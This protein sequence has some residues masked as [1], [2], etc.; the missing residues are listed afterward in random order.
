M[1]R[2][3]WEYFISL[4]M[5][6]VSI[7][8]MTES[9]GAVTTLEKD[10]M[11]LFTCGTPLKGIDIKIDNPESDGIGEICMK[12]RCIFMGYFKNEQATREIFDKDGYIHSGD[13]GSLKDGFLEIKG[14]IKELIITAGGE[15]I[16]PVLI[17]HAF[18]EVCHMCSN[19]MIIG[20]D[21]KFLSALITLKVNIDPKT[22][23][24][25]NE[26]SNECLLIMKQQ[27]KNGEQIKTV[28][29]AMKSED[30]RKYI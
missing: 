24:P 7:F 18:K 20:D 10:K 28:Q 25:S 11:K 21:R 19:I 4:D 2:R 16:A 1:N 29:D 27:I 12:G 30:V 5:A 14:R 9:A 15:N 3:T 26:L 6:P 17:E 13:L 8:G 23:K 22:G